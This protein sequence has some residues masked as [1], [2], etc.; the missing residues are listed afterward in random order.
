M[1][2]FCGEGW[3]VE[4]P[5]VV[6]KHWGLTCNALDIPIATITTIAEVMIVFL[7]ASMVPLTEELLKKYL[8]SE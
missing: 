7:W 3:G 8:L 4:L 6:V 1:A 5:K 2:T